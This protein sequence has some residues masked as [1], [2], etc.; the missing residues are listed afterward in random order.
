MKDINLHTDSFYLLIDPVYGPNSQYF[1][2]G[3]YLDA[4]HYIKAPTRGPV[5]VSGE[6]FLEEYAEE[7]SGVLAY[8][9]STD[10]PD[11]S[12]CDA[13]YEKFDSLYNH[14]ESWDSSTL[15]VS[16]V[17]RD[18]FHKMFPYQSELC[19]LRTRLDYKSITEPLLRRNLYDEAFLAAYGRPV[20]ETDKIKR[21]LSSREWAY[22]M[23]LIFYPYT[24]RAL[25][26]ELM[27]VLNRTNIVTTNQKEIKKGLLLEL[28]YT[29]AFSFL[30]KDIYGVYGERLVWGL[31]LLQI[32]SKASKKAVD[33]TLS[34]LSYGPI[35]SL[36]QAHSST[37]EESSFVSDSASAYYI[38]PRYTATDYIRDLVLSEEAY[39]RIWEEV[40]QSAANWEPT[41]LLMS[42]EEEGQKLAQLAFGDMIRELFQE[43]TSLLSIVNPAAKTLDEEELTNT[44]QISLE[45]LFSKIGKKIDVPF[46]ARKRIIEICNERGI[47]DKEV[48]AFET[49]FEAWPINK[50]NKSR[51]DVVV[52]VFALLLVYALGVFFLNKSNKE[53]SLNAQPYQWTQVGIEG[54]GKAQ[55]DTGSVL[56]IEPLKEGSPILRVL[57]D[58]FKQVPLP[59][60]MASPS[61]PNWGKFVSGHLRQE[62]EQPRRQT[63]RGLQRPIVASAKKKTFDPQNPTIIVT[64][65]DNKKFKGI[66]IKET[67]LSKNEFTLE[68]SFGRASGLEQLDTT[69]TTVAK[70]SKL[71]YV[72]SQFDHFLDSR[73]RQGIGV[74]CTRE[75][76]P[77]FVEAIKQPIHSLLTK[78]GPKMFELELGGVTIP[79]FLDQV[80]TCR[81]KV[82]LSREATDLMATLLDGRFTSQHYISTSERSAELNMRFLTQIATKRGLRTDC[83]K[84]LVCPRQLF[85]DAMDRID[86]IQ[87]Q[88]D[89]KSD[90][91]KTLETQRQLQD[92]VIKGQEYVSSRLSALAHFYDS[93]Q[94]ARDNP[95]GAI[96]R[97]FIKRLTQ[98]YNAVADLSNHIYASNVRNLRV[99]PMGR[100][101]SIDSAIYQADEMGYTDQWPAKSA[102]ERSANKKLMREFSESVL[103]PNGLQPEPELVGIETTVHY[104]D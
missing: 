65:G 5:Y 51:R 85:E 68:G 66:Y 87:T 38:A 95:E 82:F 81:T 27:A 14:V 97:D 6:E 43:N 7:L 29:D 64:E 70:N 86:D 52:S 72:R 90:S 62:K 83:F 99:P 84:S 12:Y 42:F 76:D 9:D 18:L 39:T 67:F 19:E 61:I 4:R 10:Y 26:L 55:N 20:K 74:F 13:L 50:F 40:Q 71:T 30:R 16:A 17:Y 59:K 23:G 101:F 25:I 46:K 44:E 33:E 100:V 57:R 93:Q 1:W 94:Y 34:S 35:I 31:S 53:F 63:N 75:C 103:R 2:P 89:Q 28:E 104:L 24:D 37:S 32:G 80:F 47:P 22:L 79:E 45:K 91:R 15:F 56:E 8:R 41:S 60:Q 49:I 11:R 78:E 73:T 58:T 102:R 77:N 69:A 48:L 3:S 96:Q 92:L 88:I 98:R 21:K 36:I 54:E